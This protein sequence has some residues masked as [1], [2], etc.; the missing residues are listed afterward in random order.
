MIPYILHVTVITTICYFFYKLLLQKE[1]FYRWNR[2]MLV[3]CL[4]LAFLL[5]LLPAPRIGGLWVK[6]DTVVEALPVSVTEAKP[7][8]ADAQQLADMPTDEV[9][10]PEASVVRPKVSEQP[11][12]GRGG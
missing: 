1:T 2:W 10:T 4:A 3:G 7:A 9:A 6:Q 8:E 11:A 5:P 12:G